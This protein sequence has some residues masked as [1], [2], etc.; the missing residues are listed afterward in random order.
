MI[1]ATTLLSTRLFHNTHFRLWL[2]S[3]FV[4]GMLLTLLSYINTGSFI[5]NFN[6]SGFF[7]EV[8]LVWVQ[9]LAVV[10]FVYYAAQ[11]FDN[12]YSQRSFSIYRFVYELTLV[13]LGS[14]LINAFFHWLFIKLIVIPDSD[15]IPVLERKLTNLLML[16]QTIVVI[17]YGILSI[18]RVFRNLQEEK[19][20]LLKWQKEFAQA[21]FDALKNQL[22]PHFLFNSLSALSSLVYVDAD[23]SEKFIEKLSR[24][25]RYLLEQREKEAVSIDL[26]LDFLDHYSFL[27]E[28]RYGKKLSIEK[29]I[30]S[31]GEKGFLL[32]GSFLI[33]LEYIIG[34]TAMSI[35]MPL[36]IRIS[37]LQ[38]QVDFMFPNR[39]KPLQAAHLEEQLK[40]LEARYQ[41]LGKEI[42]IRTNKLSQLNTITIPLIQTHD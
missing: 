14:F 42:A 13:V 23:K 26:E 39:V 37:I 12:R 33:C 28:Q 27:Q 24:T 32:P 9:M 38:S 10:Y 4:L 19:L 35:A 6:L 15:S 30:Q 41:L 8:P 1:P 34:S 36:Q 31:S 22:N 2:T 16:T 18:T 3:I 7:R 40:A 17:S 25:Y 5:N 29:N 20:E 11:F 21:Q